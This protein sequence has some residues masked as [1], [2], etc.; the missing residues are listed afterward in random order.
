MSANPID[1]EAAPTDASLLLERDRVRADLAATLR[2]FGRRGLQYGLAGHATVRDPGSEELYWVNPTGI[3]FESVAEDDLVLV[4]PDGEIVEGRHR[5]HGYHGQIEVHQRRPEL[6]AGFHVHS[7]HV[8][9]WSSAGGELAPLTTD[10]AWLHGLQA[11]RESFEVSAPDALGERA[12]ILIQRAHGAV[13]FGAT[14]AEAAFYFLS[15]E[16]AAYTQLLLEAAGKA[17]EV[18]RELLDGWKLT[19]E[20]AGLQFQALIDAELAAGQAPR[21]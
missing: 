21:L 18:S 16:R 10:S 6:R 5:A 19:P 17:R 8:F 3:P 2:I 4:R 13:T 1:L 9:A 20:I 15:V 12:R 7:T 14:I 11:V